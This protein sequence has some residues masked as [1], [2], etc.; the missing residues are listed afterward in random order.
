MANL[1]LVV[2]STL[3]REELLATLQADLALQ[4]P[5]FRFLRL[6]TMLCLSD[7]VPGPGST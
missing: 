4:P 3:T 2:A 5:L 1:S 6:M 7:R